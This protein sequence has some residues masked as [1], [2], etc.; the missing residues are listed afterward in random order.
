MTENKNFLVSLA[1]MENKELW[2]ILSPEGMWYD[3]KD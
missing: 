2:K 1:G 3:E